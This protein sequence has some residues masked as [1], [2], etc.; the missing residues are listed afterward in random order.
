LVSCVERLDAASFRRQ[1]RLLGRGETTGRVWGV[2][3]ARDH[4][5]QDAHQLGSQCWTHGRA[6]LSTETRSQHPSTAWWHQ[7]QRLYCL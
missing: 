6:E 4:W 3:Q 5:Q 2:S 1:G 7:G